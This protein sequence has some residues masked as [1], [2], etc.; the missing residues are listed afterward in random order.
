MT[1]EQIIKLYGKHVYQIRLEL[2]MYY[3]TNAEADPAT[4]FETADR[5]VRYLESDKHKELPRD[6][7]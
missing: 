2:G 3:F 1:R 5:F 6:V 7:K 4:A